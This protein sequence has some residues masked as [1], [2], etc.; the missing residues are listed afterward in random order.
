MRQDG[1][2]KRIAGLVGLA[3]LMAGCASAPPE[4]DVE[5]YLTGVDEWSA[6]LEIP[7]PADARTVLIDRGDAACERFEI[8]RDS[9]GSVEN[10]VEVTAAIAKLASGSGWSEG[11]RD[12]VTAIALAA[13]DHLCPA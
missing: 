10:H 7:A 8:V 4:P 2:M 11:D 1:A 6:E 9:G 3:L 13:F 5:G 12:E